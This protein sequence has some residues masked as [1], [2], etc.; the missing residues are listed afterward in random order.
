MKGNIVNKPVDTGALLQKTKEICNQISKDAEC[1]PEN[2]GNTCT[3]ED[4]QKE[5]TTDTKSG[6]CTDAMIATLQKYLFGTLCGTGNNNSCGQ[7]KPI[8]NDTKT[9]AGEAADQKE[10]TVSPPRQDGTVSGNTAVSEYE[11]AVVDLV[12]DI[13]QQHG[14]A[15]LKLNVEL[16]AVARTKSADMSAK[17]YFSHTSPTYGSPF[18]M[19]KSFGISYRTAG[20]NI[21]MGYASPQA[22]VD[23]WMNSDGHR[24]NILNASFTQIGVGYVAN[25]HYWTQMFIG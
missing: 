4:C 9:D 12:N 8:G 19:M 18:D 25:G 1:I 7:G 16:S 11:K 20:E 15:A 5:Q 17:K 24:A 3:V 2:A 23:G 21:A 22:V 14:L 13:R 10:N 6:N